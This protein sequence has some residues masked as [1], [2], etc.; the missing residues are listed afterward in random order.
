MPDPLAVL[1][2]MPILYTVYIHNAANPLKA[3]DRCL[4][5]HLIICALYAS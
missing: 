4:I 1:C 2:I 3:A 5:V